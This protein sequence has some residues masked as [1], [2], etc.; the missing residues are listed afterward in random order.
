[1]VIKSLS[2]FCLIFGCYF[3]IWLWKL[4]KLMF[5]FWR[6]NNGIGLKIKGFD[7][8]GY[9]KGFWWLEWRCWLIFLRILRDWEECGFLSWCVG[10][11]AIGS[12]TF[13]VHAISFCHPYIIKTTVFLYFS[14]YWQ[15]KL[16]VVLKTMLHCLLYHIR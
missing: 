8:M 14:V 4:H 13:P 12:V 9:D 7:D 1:M 6:L 5:N 16:H 11:S 15:S 3:W 10:E 2:L